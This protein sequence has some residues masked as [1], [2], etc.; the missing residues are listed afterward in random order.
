MDSTDAPLQNGGSS[1]QQLFEDARRK[2]DSRTPNQDSPSR[3]LLLEFSRML[4][5]SDRKFHSELDRAGAEQEKKHLEALAA[6]AAEHER[7]RQSAERVAEKF[8]LEVERERRRREEHEHRELERIRQENARIEAERR[9]RQIDD[10]K[11]QEAEQR[12]AAEEARALA[13][14][15]ERLR[16]QKAQ[17]E[18]DAAKRQAE[19]EDRERREKEDSAAAAAAA[20]KARAEETIRVQQQP[21]PTQPTQT[22]GAARAAAPVA[23]RAV[24]NSPLMSSQAE[25]EATHKE[26]LEIHQRLKVFR[27]NFQNEIKN[28]PALKKVA[29]DLRRSM[30]MRMGQLT[31]NI[32]QNKEP[33]FL[34]SSTQSQLAP[35]PCEASALLV[36]LFNHF[37]KAII[38]QLASEAGVNTK[39]ADPI[40]VVAVSILGR[41]DYCISNKVPFTDILLAKY[42]KSCGV[43]FG[44][45][46][47]E[48]TERGR[49]R[50]GWRRVEGTWCSDQ[51][52]LERMTGLGAGWA[53]LT[54][55][56]I[57][58]GS[59][60]V[61]PLPIAHYWRAF[62]RIVN[63]PTHEATATHYMV[64]KAMVEGN[65]LERFIN[66]YG[67]AAIAALRKGFIEF[68]LGH[69]SVAAKSMP[70]FVE[71][72][73]KEH[74]LTL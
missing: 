18:A 5:D 61:H 4:I 66:A 44:I 39:A 37:S 19:R 58:P 49:Q 73:K 48:K 34:A 23:Q 26:Y 28:N 59:A 42:H 74:R 68:P 57:K 30:R 20:Q 29:G 15:E 72:A 33:Q 6:A 64:L 1:S 7:V 10:V 70:G 38:A 12:R 24:S 21:A 3:Q 14:A 65:A 46:G 36:F 35:G 40:G 13:E 8:R 32:K 43:L 53:S 51:D 71:S 69:D 47:P 16:K 56:K 55:R 67:K 62:S 11:R 45:Y 63:T 41:P 27:K 60:L 50:L 52:H 25:R 2:A 17:E 22:N 54:L 9:Q 31:L